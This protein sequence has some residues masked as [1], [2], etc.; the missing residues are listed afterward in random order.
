MCV[1]VAQKYVLI[2]SDESERTGKIHVLFLTNV[3][4]QFSEWVVKFVM[5]FQV[6]FKLIHD[7]QNIRA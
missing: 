7:L 1:S 5:I 3:R 4:F 6:T 2:D